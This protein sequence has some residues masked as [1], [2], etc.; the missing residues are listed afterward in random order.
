[1]KD[2]GF[3]EV[4]LILGINL[5]VGIVSPHLNSSHHLIVPLLK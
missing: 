4:L 1:M 2:E 3:V 5:N